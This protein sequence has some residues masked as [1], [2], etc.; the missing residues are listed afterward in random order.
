MYI[1]YI[2]LLSFSLKRDILK[3]IASNEPKIIQKYLED[4]LILLQNRINQ[5]KTELTIQSLSC[6][7]ILVTTISLEMID[8]R[9]HEFVR[10][11]H[12]D[13]TRQIKY[14]VS[15]LKDYIREK[16]LF[17]ELSSS[18]PLTNEKVIHI[19]IFFVFITPILCYTI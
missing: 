17:H 19:L 14:H 16:Q 2:D 12:L 11:H 15:K 3:I 8:Q 13:L 5:Y 10:L 4:Y 7:V 6:P 1:N 9:L 18:Y